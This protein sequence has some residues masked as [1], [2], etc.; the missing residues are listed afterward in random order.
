ML[1]ELTDEEKKLI[2]GGK[3]IGV[4]AALQRKGFFSADV[5]EVVTTYEDEVVR[6]IVLTDDEEVLARHM[7][8]LAL[9]QN[10]Q[11]RG[12]G[13]DIASKAANIFSGVVEVRCLD[14]GNIHHCKKK[15]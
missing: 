6:G 9:I 2:K 7:A 3:T 14:C 10:F 11:A 1:I 13:Y 5:I 4:R 15:S 8:T 12:Y